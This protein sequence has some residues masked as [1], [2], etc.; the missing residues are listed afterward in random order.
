MT[1]SISRSFKES[2]DVKSAEA[3]L[4]TLQEQRQALEKQFQAEISDTEKK[5]NPLTE[6]LEKVLISPARN[7]VSVRLLALTWTPV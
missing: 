4:R 1:R 3:Q 5:T 6:N 2:G 7:D